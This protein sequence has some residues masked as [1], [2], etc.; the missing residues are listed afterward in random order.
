MRRGFALALVLLGLGCRPKPPAPVDQTPADEPRADAD[1]PKQVRDPERQP[2]PPPTRP[3]P[4][5]DEGTIC[6]R[7][8]ADVHACVLLDDPNP[9][10]AAAI[11]L[12][13][14]DACVR[15]REPFVA[16]TPPS[17]ITATACTAYRSCVREAWPDGSR[18]A[19]VVEGSGA[20]C[21]LICT[22]FSECFGQGYEDIE[23]CTQQCRESLD[24]EAERA[25]GECTKLPDCEQV[26][27]CISELLKI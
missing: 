17:A 11:E 13:C 16:C 8:C 4:R 15:A 7:R 24:G 21:P 18:P 10:A 20:G 3:E 12:G 1:G 23:G 27:M 25:M 5:A 2:D 6:E 22:R 14:L 9:A 26:M 19:T